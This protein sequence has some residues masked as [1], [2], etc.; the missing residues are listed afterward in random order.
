MTKTITSFPLSW[1][2]AFLQSKL[3]AEQSKLETVKMMGARSKINTISLNVK[4]NKRKSVDICGTKFY[5]KRLS[6]NENIIE[7]H[8]GA[9]FLTRCVVV[10]CGYYYYNHIIIVRTSSCTVM[11]VESVVSC[12]ERVPA[13]VGQRC[14]ESQTYGVTVLR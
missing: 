6:Q 12:S 9:T 14:G 13:V 2:S 1:Y 11:C 4:V 8:R 5:A 3:I 7:S 10:A